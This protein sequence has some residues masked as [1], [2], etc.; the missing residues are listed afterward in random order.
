MQSNDGFWALD[1]RA[2]HV[3]V[4]IRRIG[5]EDRARLEHGVQL[6]EYLAL[7][8]DVFEY[9]FD[10]QIDIA[11]RGIIVG[12]DDQRGAALPLIGADAAGGDH[13]VVGGADAG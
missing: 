10:R 13:T 12:S 6:G 2:E 4:E 7:D 5:A 11:E 9:G 3:E 1:L 8:V